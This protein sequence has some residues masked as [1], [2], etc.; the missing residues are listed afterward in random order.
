MKLCV[1]TLYVF[2]AK[3]ELGVRG[4]KQGKILLFSSAQE[5]NYTGNIIEEV[6]A[7]KVL[8]NEML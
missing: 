3:W 5:V 2:W 6:K 4:G 8:I 7:I 1:Y